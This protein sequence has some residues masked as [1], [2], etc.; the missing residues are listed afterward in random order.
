MQNF[1]STLL[2]FASEQLEL[3]ATYVHYF[4]QGLVDAKVEPD[5]FTTELQRE[6]HSSLNPA[7]F[8]F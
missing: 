1:L 4:I 3:V 6:L 7:P 2:G 5:E 8:H